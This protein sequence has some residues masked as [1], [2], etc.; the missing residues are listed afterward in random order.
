MPECQ[1]LRDMD[2][3]YCLGTSEV[4][5]R[6][7]Y[8]H[9]AGIATRRQT[10]PLH[11]LFQQ[12]LRIRQQQ[13]HLAVRLGVAHRTIDA[14]ALRLY[15]PSPDDTLGDHG[16]GLTWRR[17]RQ[18]RSTRRLHVNR[19]IDSVQYRSAH[20]ILIVFAATGR[21]SAFPPPLP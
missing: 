8:P 4:G 19:K 3:L 5:D 17:M 6:A 14:I 10:Q 11:R 1:R 15:L 18:F 12:F 20:T 2:P 9:R 21:P 16:T 13:D 7:P